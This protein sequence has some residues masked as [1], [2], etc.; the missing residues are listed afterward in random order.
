MATTSNDLLLASIAWF[1]RGILV[2]VGTIAFSAIDV[3]AYPPLEFALKRTGTPIFYLDYNADSTPDRAVGYGAATDIGLVGDFDGDTITD[4]AVYRDGTW[5]IDYFNDS[6]ADRVVVFGG[7]PTTDAPIVSDF[8]ADGKADIGV[9]RNNGVWYLDFNLDGVPDRISL[10]GGAAGDVPVVADF[11][12]DGSGDRAIYRQGQWYVDYDWNGTAEAV[13]ILGGAPQDVPLAAD[14]NNDGLADLVIFRD[15]VWYTDIDRNGTADQIRFYGAAGDRPL[16][17]YFNIAGSVFVRAGATGAHDGSQRM[18]YSTIGGAMSS[19]PPSNTIIR[20][21]G[22]SYPERVS[23]SQKPNLTFQ[24]AG[25]SATH[26]NPSAGDVF[27]AFRCQGTTLRDIHFISQGPDGTTPG[28]GIINLGSSMTLEHI[29][30]S[31]GWDISLIAAQF[32]GSPAT[33]NV[34]RSSFDSSRIGNG[35]QLDT[36]SSA[37]VNRS[38]ASDNGT[39]PANIPPLPAA[40]GGRGVVLFNNAAITVTNTNISRNYDGGI[41]MTHTSSAV[42]RNNFVLQ[43]GTAGAYYE[44]QATGEIT[45]NVFAMNG[46]RGTRGP[47]GNNGVEIAGLAAPMT[48]SGNTFS[49]NTLNGIFVEDGTVNILNNT[50]FYNYVG[51]TVANS[52]NRPVNI[53]IRGNLFDLPDSPL[54]S[55]GVFMQSSTAATMII[56]IGGSAAADKNTFRNFGSFPAIHCFQSTI[57]A[58]CPAAGNVFINGT[59]PVQNCPSCSP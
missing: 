10:L 39:E 40:P 49:T 23:I 7:P 4:L 47:G 22:G 1:R 6:I 56:T 46:A 42:L 54:Y 36:G 16:V 17:G 45:G 24:G 43:N 58:L 44:L 5:F 21:A 32:Q 15:G 29:S 51:V 55:E 37:T 52:R 2:L 57:S 48:I 28:R 19:N 12:G 53:L 9:Y 11:N 26:I 8:N 30:T 20:I 50:F 18:P 25:P 3:F 13:Y 14:F 33:L 31:G 35:I 34:D 41:L 38:S 59:F 27:S